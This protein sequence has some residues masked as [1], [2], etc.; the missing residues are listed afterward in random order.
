MADRN[1]ASVLP[2]PVGAAISA[3]WCCEV[4]CQACDCADVGALKRDVNHSATAGWNGRSCM[5]Q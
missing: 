3:F 2:E 5:A 4:A 1:A